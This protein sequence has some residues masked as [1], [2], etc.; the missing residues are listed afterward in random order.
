MGTY[1]QHTEWLNQTLNTCS[2]VHKVAELLWPGVWLLVMVE[3]PP[4]LLVPLVEF[5]D[6]VLGQPPS[7]EFETA[8]HDGCEQPGEDVPAN[9]AAILEATNEPAKGSHKM[10]EP[11]EGNAPGDGSV[12]VLGDFAAFVLDVSDEPPDSENPEDSADSPALDSPCESCSS[13]Q[14][15]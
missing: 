14:P 4:F 11:G 13:V 7:K 5:D 6:A 3:V 8:N 10:E 12:V 15:P 9:A 2:I 1:W